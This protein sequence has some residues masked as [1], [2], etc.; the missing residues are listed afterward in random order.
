MLRLLLKPAV[1]GG[2]RGLGRTEAGGCWESLWRPL[3]AAEGC[4]IKGFVI[5]EKM[6]RIQKSVPILC[7]YKVFYIFLL[8]LRE[9]LALLL[10]CV[11][12]SE[13]LCTVACQGSLFMGFPRQEYW[14][15][16][17]FPPPGDLPDS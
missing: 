7:H 10:G 13:T 9:V 8:K 14:N 17:P 12:L 2:N 16:L 11:Q 1:G 4:L 3:C 5:S 6:L 15:G